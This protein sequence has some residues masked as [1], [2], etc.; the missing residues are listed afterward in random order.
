MHGSTDAASR[1]ANLVDFEGVASVNQ[2]ATS[3]AHPRASKRVV[4]NRR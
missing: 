4:A 2:T 3:H 1:L